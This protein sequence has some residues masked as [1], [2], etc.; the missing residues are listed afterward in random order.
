MD[1]QAAKQAERQAE[2]EYS[3]LRENL[4]RQIV[5]TLAGLEIDV[6]AEIALDREKGLPE[7][8]LNNPEYIEKKKDE[9]YRRQVQ[10]IVYRYLQ[11]QGLDYSLQQKKNIIEELIN[12]TRGLGILQPIL[13]DKTVTE[14]MVNG[15]APILVE[16]AGRIV[17][18]ETRFDNSKELERIIR[19]IVESV[20]REINQ[21]SPIVDA[22]LADGSRVNAV[23]PPIA[24]NGPILTI[25]K[26]PDKPLMVEDLIRWGSITE[27]VAEILKVLVAARYNIF[28]SGGTGSGKTT[29]LNMLSNFIPKD[30]R[31]I[32]IEDAAELRINGITNLVRLEARKSANREAGL[33][34][35]I[36]ELI[37]A[38]LRMRPDR[39]V[40]GEV[41]GEEALDMLQAMNTGHDG[42]LSTGHANSVRDMMSRLETMVLMGV[43]LPLEAIRQQIASALDIVIHLGRL[44]DKSR[45]T[46]EICEVLDYNVQTK[47]VEL[48]PLFRFEEE[49]SE[50]KKKVKGR[51]QRTGN[52]LQSRLKLQMAGYELDI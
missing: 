37:K 50:D 13:E 9:K 16:R 49:P 31:I 33:D 43:E 3:E 5:E 15:T 39:V 32:T 19:K 51:L 45:K 24:L 21:S 12:I 2:K 18:L 36:R 30:E 7:H 25:R 1:E 27:E 29:F 22:R 41:R 40:V 44:R 10:E 4:K 42:S 17:E 38:S 46:L 23:F 28:V 26:F 14:V 34:I 52:K 20:N 8:Q 48:N 11:Y 6:S 47:Q 35:P